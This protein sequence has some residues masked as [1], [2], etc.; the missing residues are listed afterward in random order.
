MRKNLLVVAGECELGGGI[1]YVGTFLIV[2]GWLG[3]ICLVLIGM[4]N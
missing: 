2:L 1:S 3:L 4:K